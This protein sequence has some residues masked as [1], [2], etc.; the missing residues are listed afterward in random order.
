LAGKCWAARLTFWGTRTAVFGENDL[1]PMCPSEPA[2]SRFR[3]FLPWVVVVFLLLVSGIIYGQTL[4]F[5]FLDYDDSLFVDGSREVRAGL[6]GSSVVWAFTNG[7][8]GEWYPLSM[9]SHML[10]CELYGL[11]ASGHHLTSVLLHAAAAIGLFFVWRSMTGELWPSALV[12]ALFAIHPQHVESVA[13]VAERRDV[14]SGMFF[15]L[16]LAAYLGYV[17]RNRT[18]GRYLL[19]A[20]VFS[21]GLMSKAML[22][23]VPPLLLLLDYWPL[24]R[25]GRTADRAPAALA[26]PRQDIGWLVIEKLPLLAIALADCAVTLATHAKTPRALSLA[27][28]DRLSNAVVALVTYLCQ[29]FYPVNLAV[30]YP[31]PTGGNPV[32]KVAG[33]AALLAAVS[34]A[35]TAWRR[36]R[37]YLFVGWFWFLGMLVPVLGLVTVSKHAMADRY[38]YLPGIGLY[39]AVAWGAA[40]LASGS[41]AGRWLVVTGTALAIATLTVL[42]TWQTSH[43]R[44]ELALW[45]HARATTEENVETETNLA[46]ALSGVNRLDEAI[47]HYRQAAK[48]RT[49]ASLL[50]SLGTTLARQGKLDEAT[51]EFRQALELDPAYAPA[52][53]NLGSALAL[54]GESKEAAYHYLRAIELDS[55]FALPHFKLANLLL[56]AGKIDEA[57]AHFERVIALDPWHVAAHAGLAAAH[58]ERGETDRAIAEYE[59]ALALDPGYSSAQVALARTLAACGRVDEA[60]AHCRRALEVAPNDAAA[61]QTLDQLLD[62]RSHA[63]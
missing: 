59:A 39:V 17:R 57:V 51:A 10:D 58:A 11:N 40:R 9:L 24:G 60:I 14:L 6:T 53:A 16:T 4:E 34:L 3:A 32:W 13:W 26:L 36:R 61:R 33:A 46:C 5:G 37:P 1:K 18:L 54:R 31:I 56:K 42:A 30:F 44:D 22:V 50:N 45:T 62:A 48:W 7:P 15:V 38:M 52:H 25:F 20:V 23:T 8:M 63:P 41:L 28:P 2:T 21:M 27:W 49:D 43:W 12:A 35:A 47:E 55:S 29:F 19:M